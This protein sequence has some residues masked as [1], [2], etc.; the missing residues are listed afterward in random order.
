[1]VTWHHQVKRIMKWL[2]RVFFSATVGFQVP[3]TAFW[4]PK[5]LAMGF[6]FYVA[7]LGKILMGFL[8]SPFN[9]SSFL[10][11]AFSMSTWGEFAFIIAVEAK[12]ENLLGGD[13]YAAVILAVMLSILVSPYCLRLSLIYNADEQKHRVE[14]YIHDELIHPAHVYYKLYIRMHNV[15]GLQPEIIHLMHDVQLKSIEFRAEV[16][17]DFVLYEAYI[18]DLT[19]QDD[20]PDTAD[21]NGLDARMQFLNSKLLELLHA[22]D[23]GVEDAGVDM[24]DFETLHGFSLI[25]WL[26]GDTQEEWVEVGR[27]E[28]KA[29]EKMAMQGFKR[30][31]SS[32]SLVKSGPNG[33]TVAASPEKQQQKQH[34][35]PEEEAKAASAAIAAKRRTYAVRGYSFRRNSL[36]DLTYHHDDGDTDTA[37]DSVR[38][39]SIDYES[40]NKASG[41]GIAMTSYQEIKGENKV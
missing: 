12:K 8:A 32:T 3:I 38:R 7:C 19:L 13:E 23:S 30:S 34:M 22:K 10:L 36:T 1:M 28:E 24:K 11:V 41:R 18:K 15:W 25:R 20:T 26:P 17:D 2:L 5:V 40:A 21:A 9:L 4:T 37:S 27:N 31:G 35:T 39:P 16:V 14:E 6:S 33:E 29:K